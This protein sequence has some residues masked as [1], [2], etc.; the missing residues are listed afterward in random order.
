MAKG[1]RLQEGARGKGREEGG[2]NEPERAR[3]R[4]FGPTR[5][6]LAE[7]FGR[8]VAEVRASLTLEASDRARADFDFAGAEPATAAGGTRPGEGAGEGSSDDADA[9]ATACARAVYD[10][11][12]GLGDKP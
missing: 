11:A 3:T 12:G 1:P 2:E 10:L 9:L 5:A 6:A 8:V 4:A 7:G